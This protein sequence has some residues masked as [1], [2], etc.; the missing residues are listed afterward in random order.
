MDRAD[1]GSPAAGAWVNLAQVHLHEPSTYPGAPTPFGSF[2]AD[3]SGN[4]DWAGFYPT[5][6]RLALD[7]A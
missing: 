4:G 6:M 1:M 5:P 2:Y 7:T 3:V